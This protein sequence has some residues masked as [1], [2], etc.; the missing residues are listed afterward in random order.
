MEELPP[1]VL[2]PEQLGGSLHSLLGESLIDDPCIEKCCA[3]IPQ[4]ADALKGGMPVA[5]DTTENLEPTMPTDMSEGLTYEALR[6]FRD[7]P[8]DRVCTSTH[9]MGLDPESCPMNLTSI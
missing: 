5:A 7:E 8:P 6:K 2:G 1:R 3:S 9:L 4:R